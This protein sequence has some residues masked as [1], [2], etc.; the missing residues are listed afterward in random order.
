M[1]TNRIISFTLVN[2][3]ILLSFAS[4]LASC[5]KKLYPKTGHFAELSTQSRSIAS[6]ED[7]TF[8]SFQ[9]P[10]QIYIYC[11]LNAKDENSCYGKELKA[12]LAKFEEKFGKLGQQELTDLLDLYRLEN[13]KKDADI[14]TQSLLNHLEP[15]I[16]KNVNAQFRFCKQNAKHFF[17]KCMSQGIEK[18]TFKVLNN[19]HK[20]NQLNGQEY[21]YMKDIIKAQM[22]KKVSDQGTLIL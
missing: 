17:K 5:Q 1:K 16:N 15:N 7:S 14:K 9:D 12:S 2:G 10:T 6:V 3:F 22:G 11:H 18:D 13:V 21:L 4:I 19:F 8:K 20:K